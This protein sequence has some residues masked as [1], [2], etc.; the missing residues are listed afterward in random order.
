KEFSHIAFRSRRMLNSE[1]KIVDAKNLW[2]IDYLEKTFGP[3]K[4]SVKEIT[5]QIDNDIAKLIRNL[6][7]KY[8]FE[9]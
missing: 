6:K 8:V 4:T 3:D 2:E 9:M 5:R 1:G 7:E